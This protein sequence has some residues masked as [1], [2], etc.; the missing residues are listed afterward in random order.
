MLASGQ[1]VLADETSNTDL[2]WALRGGGNNFGIVTKFHYNLYDHGIMYAGYQVFEEEHFSAV[3]EAYDHQ[4]TNCP[5]DP[6]A[7]GWLT[8]AYFNKTRI[9]LPELTYAKNESSPSIYEQ[10][11][12]LPNIHSTRNWTSLAAHTIRSWEIQPVN[13]RNVYHTI[14]TEYSPE[15][16]IF[17]RELFYEMITAFPVDE[18]RS[19]VP[20][21]IQHPIT[22]PQLRYMRNRGGNALGLNPDGPALQ[23]HQFAI[24]WADEHDDEKMYRFIETF[25]DRLKEKAEEMGIMHRFLYMNYASMFQDVI[26]GY[27]EENKKR[28]IEVAEQYDPTGVFQTLQPGHFKLRGGPWRSVDEWVSA[29]KSGAKQDGSDAGNGSLW[30]KLKGRHDEL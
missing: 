26:A 15:V 3:H 16:N 29:K 1:I 18:I 27:G 12:E 14:T 13:H 9:V 17:G 11:L 7:Q 23:I 22:T 19:L 8:W 30:D 20:A 21:Y 4:V 5:S 6:H 10:Y 28:L 25:F 2:F 24:A